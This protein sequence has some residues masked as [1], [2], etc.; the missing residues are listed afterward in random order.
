MVQR[1]DKDKE[2]KDPV[3]EG[4]KLTAEKALEKPEVKKGLENLWDDLPAD[5]QA[6]LISFGGLSL[7]M[8]YVSLI[9]SE[10]MR[11]NLSDVD[12]GKPLSLI[13]YVP[14]ES[15]KYKLPP[16]GGAGVGLSAK[17]SF[18]DYFELLRERVPKVPITDLT[19]SLEG[20]LTKGSG[21]SPT[22]GSFGLEFFG[23]ALK[24]EGK[25]FTELSPYPML[26]PGAG[27]DPPSMLMQSYPELPGM[28][29][30]LGG[31]V[32]I[33]ADLAKFFPRL[34]GGGVPLF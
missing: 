4:L 3:V 5:G 16:P 6:A 11:E 31:Q 33:S 23:G 22:G 2:D 14:I 17:V 25:T 28:Q 27:L 34:L 9:Y 7:G 19:F 13:P 10:K 8:A 30:G 29:T 1:E 18:A 24:A 32:T 12:I 26:I 15:F 20:T 21:F